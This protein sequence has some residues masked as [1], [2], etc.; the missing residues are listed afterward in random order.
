MNKITI[1]GASIIDYIGKSFNDIIFNDSNPGIL[2]TY[3]GGVGRNIAE[4]LAL[5][6][7]NVNFITCIG[8]DELG[9]SL[10]KYMQSINVTL[11]YPN[12]FGQTCSYVAMHDNNGKMVLGL[13]DLTLFDNLTVDFIEQNKSVIEESI[14]LVVDGNL[15]EEVIDYIFLNFSH[16]LII[17][18]GISTAKV[19]KFKKYLSKIYLLKTNELEYSVLNIN[20]INKPSNLII[21]RGASK[22]SLIS[23]N[24]ITYDIDAL[25][26][27]VNETGAGDALLSGVIYGLLNNISLAESI[28]IGIKF[29][30]ITLLCESAVNKD[31]YSLYN[32]K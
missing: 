32:K 17:V 1:I 3:F 25:D 19:V 7:Q 27:I 31:L 2:K 8:N 21:T 23:E 29:S 18:D 13:S 16:K 5:M 12:V 28:Y 4:N 22:L 24:E 9:Y 30:R 10:K 20:K 11:Y 14:Y 15:K 26:S 6:Q